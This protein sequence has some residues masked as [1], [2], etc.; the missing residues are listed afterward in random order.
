MGTI[1]NQFIDV[2]QNTSAHVINNKPQIYDVC[3]NPITVNFTD[4]R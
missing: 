2:N 4:Y 1:S 3:T